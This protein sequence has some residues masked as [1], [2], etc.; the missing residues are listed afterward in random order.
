MLNGSI[1]MNHQEIN[2]KNNALSIEKD[3]IWLDQVIS[4]RLESYFKNEPFKMPIPPDTLKTES[5]YYQFLIDNQ[6]SLIERFIIATC[7]SSLF[8]P[9]VFDKLLIKNK[10]LD[11]RFTEFGGKIDD[12]KSIFIP[13]IQTIAFIFFGDRFESIFQLQK[14]LNNNSLFRTKDFIEINNDS[15]KNLFFTSTLNLSEELVQLFTVGIDYKPNYSSNFPANLITT[16]LDWQDLILSK[17]TLDEVLIVNT[18][19]ENKIEINNNKILEKKINKGYKCLFFG[20][21]GTG[22]TLTASLIGKKNNKDVYR[23][24][25]SQVVSKYIGETEKNLAKIFDIAEN[26]DW[27]L[28]FDEAESLF[29]KRTSVQD[30][31]DKYANQQTAYLLQRIENYNGLIILATNLKPNI[32]QAFSRRIQSMINFPIPSYKERII[33]WVNALNGIAELDK[34]FIDQIANTYEIS[35]GVIKNVIQYAWLLSKSTGNE[36]TANH[37]LSGIKRELFKDGKS[38]ED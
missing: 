30:S 28:F 21:P 2:I 18:W 6:L 24:D 4:E 3:I 17:N 35:G 10:P 1:R 26:K 37:I 12:N 33:L 32:D 8:K 36:I 38:F 19:I 5:K 15:N 16:K 14:I 7:L 31:K 27:I 9:Q 20:P 22:K 11:K 29:S 25:L 23:I 13:T 34:K